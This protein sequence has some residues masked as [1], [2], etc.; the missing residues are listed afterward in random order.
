M[1]LKSAIMGT[2]DPR[3]LL[4]E[5]GVQ[6]MQ[7]KAG[8]VAG[9]LDVS[10][11]TRRDECLDAYRGYITYHIDVCW[12]CNWRI[13]K[14]LDVIFPT[15]EFRFMPLDSIFGSNCPTCGEYVSDIP[16]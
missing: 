14:Q 10:Q 1:N 15:R 8:Y 5:A 3:A 16:F 9:V 7:R 12:N 11:I 4:L 6:G 13:R 2:E